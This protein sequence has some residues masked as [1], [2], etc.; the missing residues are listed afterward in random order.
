MR[1]EGKPHPSRY[2]LCDYFIYDLSNPT[3]HLIDAGYFPAAIWK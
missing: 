1:S 2:G 3:P